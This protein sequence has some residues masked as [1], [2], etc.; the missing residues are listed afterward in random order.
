MLIFT[1]W[2]ENEVLESMLPS[3]RWP[4]TD[5]SVFLTSDFFSLNLLERSAVQPIGFQLGALCPSLLSL[6]CQLPS[7]PEANLPPA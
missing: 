6:S 7:L 1:K 4:C 2:G 3:P 5:R